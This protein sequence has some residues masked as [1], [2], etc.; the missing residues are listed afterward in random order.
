MKCAVLA[1]G[2]QVKKEYESLQA[3][4]YQGYYGQPAQGYGYPAYGGYGVQA[5]YGGYAAPPPAPAAPQKAVL[6]PGADDAPP[7][8]PPPPV[9]SQLP[10][11]IGSAPPPPPPPPVCV[12]A[13]SIM[14]SC[15]DRPRL[16]R[17]SCSVWHLRSV[18]MTDLCRCGQEVQGGGGARGQGRQARQDRRRLLLMRCVVVHFRKF[19]SLAQHAHT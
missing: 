3:A 7:P 4:Q 17:Q 19:P 12:W 14:T 8:V 18:V 15:H 10:L 16:S 1:H 2:V 5:P 13:A 11:G 6:P 9:V